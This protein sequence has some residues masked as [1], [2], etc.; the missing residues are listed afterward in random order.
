MRKTHWT[1]VF[2]FAAMLG[3]VSTPAYAQGKGKGK[4]E[5]KEQHKGNKVEHAEGQ[6][7]AEGRAKAHGNS[8][9]QEHDQPH[10]Q[11]GKVKGS[12]HDGD[13]DRDEWKKRND[14]WKKDGKGHGKFKRDFGE[15]DVHPGLR[16]YIASNRAPERMAAGAVSRAFARGTDNTL[17]VITPSGNLV[18]IT[19]RSGNRLLELDENRARNLGAWDVTPFE[20]TDDAR[21]PSFC[22]SG[23]GHPVFGRQWC[24]DKGFGLGG[25]RETRWGSTDNA[26][27][28]VFG[29]P[30]TSGR[31]TRDQLLG[32]LGDVAFNRLALHAVTL[33]YADPLTGVWVGDANGPRVLQLN[34][35]SY[36]VAEIVD[37]NRDNRADRLVVALRPW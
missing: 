21:A 31:I 28:I 1:S 33:G 8:Q 22:R 37:F 4:G 27:N 16:Q 11:S 10:A 2:V 13:R 32:L 25:D 15:R 17:F 9:K 35:G 34:S 7:K 30:V 18:R 5:G 12:D 14:D 26:S 36:P 6:Q 29:Q 3:A 20:N 24:I 23:S 19:N